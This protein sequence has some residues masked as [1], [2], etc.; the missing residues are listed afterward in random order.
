[1]I[2]CL[3]HG[4]QRGTRPGYIEVFFAMMGFV[5]DALK[6]QVWI[7]LMNRIAL[8]STICISLTNYLTND[9][10]GMGALPLT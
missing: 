10:M 8:Q 6:Y 7:T 4:C 5:I 1:M 2:L 9:N 3:K